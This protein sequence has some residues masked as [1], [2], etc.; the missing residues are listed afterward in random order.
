MI[1]ANMVE[2]LGDQ[3]AENVNNRSSYWLKN[4]CAL[5]MNL[6]LHE[7]AMERCVPFATKILE[8]VVEWIRA[9]MIAVSY[10]RC[11]L[12]LFQQLDDLS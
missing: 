4:I 7:E 2:W 3:L 8:S 6:C 9:A 5:F 10:N 11:H 12:K 1:E